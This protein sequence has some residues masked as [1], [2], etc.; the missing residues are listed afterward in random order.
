MPFAHRAV[1]RDALLVAALKA[2][3][4]AAVLASGFRAL[5]DDDYARIVIAERFAEAPSLDPSGTSWLPLPFWV[6]GSAMALFGA[7]VET[8][9]SVAFL[10]GIGSVLLV[11]VSARWLGMGRRAA[12]LGAGVAA[13]FP[14]S[15]W[16]GVAAVPELPTAALALF[17]LASLSKQ[18]KERFAGAVAIALGCLSRYEVWAVAAV[19]ALVSA[20][21][22]RRGSRVLL[23]SALASVSG[24][25]LWLL[26]GALRH[27]DAFFFLE[28]VSAYRRAIGAGGVSLSTALLRHPAML[29]RAEPELT[30]FVL[31]GSLAALAALPRP[32]VAGLWRAHRRAVLGL[33]ALVAFLIAGDLRDGAATHHAERALASVWL[34]LALFGADGMGRAWGS[35]R[36]GGRAALIAGTGIALAPATAIVRPWYSARD[37]FIDRSHEVAIGK[38]ARARAREGD[39]LLVD[40]PDFAFY[41][42]IAGFGAPSRAEP[43]DDRD[44]RKPRQPD[45]WRAPSALAELVREQKATF[46]VVP[47][48]RS[49]A[50]SAVGDIIEERGSLLL[51]RAR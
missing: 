32:A 18:G 4:S 33:A 44:P 7:S 34:W 45:P 23:A 21:D 22:G 27:E 9:R 11:W 12:L 36:S 39:R 13:L 37:S 51:I 49:Q 8:A 1:P 17:A 50:V 19:F 30:A 38:A 46:L 25:A 2:V 26:N 10:A 3:V 41:S 6:N 24:A 40:T 31:C 16:L 29:L 35:L 20:W 15:A 5:S 47:K 43:F 28:R 48:E 42:V 14:Y